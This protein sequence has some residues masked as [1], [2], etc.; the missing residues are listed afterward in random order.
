MLRIYRLTAILAFLFMAVLVSGC[1]TVVGYPSP[2]EEGIAEEETAEER[3][4]EYYESEYGRPYPYYDSYYG[5]G[6]YYGLWYPSSYYYRGRP[7]WNYGYYYPRY[8]YDDYYYRGYYAPEKRPD[9]KRRGAS[10]LRRAPRPQDRIGPRLERDEES[11]Q[12]ERRT[13][14]RRKVE[15]STRRA[16][17]KRRDTSSEKKRS[18]RRKVDDEE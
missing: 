14:G 11:R 16:P 5:L 13:P 1:Y 17:E 9:T 15:G 10:E 7:W 18:S 2:V 8:Y 4:Y 3:T 6:S 12:S